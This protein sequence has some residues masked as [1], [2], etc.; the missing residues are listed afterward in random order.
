ML[1]KFFIISIGFCLLSSCSPP[2]ETDVNKTNSQGLTDTS[3]SYRSGVS[4]DQPLHPWQQTDYVFYN[5]IG[6]EI[7][8]VDVFSLPENIQ[9]ILLQKNECAYVENSVYSE[10]IRAPI[11]FDE[12]SGKLVCGNTLSDVNNAEGDCKFKILE[13]ERRDAFKRDP[14][15]PVHYLEF[16]NV[17]NTTALFEKAGVPVQAST[18]EQ[19][20]YKSDCK[21]WSSSQFVKF[22]CECLNN[23]LRIMD[24]RGLVK[25]IEI[26]FLANANEAIQVDA[27]KACKQK[28]AGYNEKGAASYLEHPVPL[29]QVTSEPLSNC[30]GKSR[31]L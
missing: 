5:K 28:V 25:G 27:D 19:T 18:S 10:K 29:N 24:Q 1:R 22:H 9:S 11:F 12:N 21:S 6:K 4:A 26:H 31:I 8:I 17:I 30:S 3:S 23:G 2:S 16:Y 15:S 14:K 13:Q 7:R 20:R